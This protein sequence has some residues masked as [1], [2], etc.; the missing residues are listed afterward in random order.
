MSDEDRGFE[1]HPLRV[2][3][4]IDQSVGQWDDEP[5]LDEIREIIQKADK[6]LEQ[7]DGHNALVPH[8]PD[9]VIENARRRAESI[10]NDGKAQ[11]Y[12]HAIN[13]L[14]R[15]RAAYLQLGQQEEWKRYRTMLLQTHTRKRKLVSML[16]QRDLT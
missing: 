16:Q 13:W 10:M 1:S 11:Y 7:G 15:V 8:R 6:F 12:Y 3:R 14:R 2:E 9:W 5:A 4:I